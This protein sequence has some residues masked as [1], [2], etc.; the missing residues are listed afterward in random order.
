MNER[1]IVKEFAEHWFDNF[2]SI[3]SPLMR[4]YCFEYPITHGNENYRAD[5][6]LEEETSTIPMENQL[7][8]I[9]FKKNKILHSALDQLNLYVSTI[10]QR[11]YRKKEAIGI[12]AAPDFSKWEV[13]ECERSGR[14]CLQYNLKGSM[15]FI[16]AEDKC[17]K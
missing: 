9:E 1:S 15:R 17:L 2:K 12:L 5:I 10:T 8:I 16:T 14:L 3:T 7:Y 11:L 13:E 4:V 6:L